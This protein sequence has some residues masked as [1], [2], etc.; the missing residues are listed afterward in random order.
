M[1][2]HSGYCSV[3][4]YFDTGEQVLAIP[5]VYSVFSEFENWITEDVEW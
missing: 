1:T 2:V 3:N 5:I 4:D